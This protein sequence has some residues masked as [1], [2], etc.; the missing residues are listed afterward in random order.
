M[1]V[2]STWCLCW[3]VRSGF[4]GQV[5]RLNPVRWVLVRLGA[6]ALLVILGRRPLT[7]VPMGFWREQ[8]RVGVMGGVID[9]GRTGRARSLTRL[10]RL[11]SSV[12]I[13]W[14]N[15][16]GHNVGGRLSA[17]G[18]RPRQREL[19]DGRCGELRLRAL[20]SLDYARSD[21]VQA[22]S[23][24]M[25]MS[26][27]AQLLE[28]IRAS[29][30]PE[31]MDSRIIAIDGLGGAGKTTL[32]TLIS[33][34]LDEC[35]VIHTDDF[36]SWENNLDWWP[37]LRNQVLEPLRSNRTARYQR[38]DWI[39]RELGEWV[40]VAPAPFIILEGVSSSRDQ[41]RGDLSFTVWVQTPRLQRLCRGLAR[42][43]EQMRSYWEQWMRDEDRYF[44]R[45]RPDLRADMVVDGSRPWDSSPLG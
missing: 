35:P 33:S 29:V 9:Q 30:P 28:G 44:A 32:A 18:T 17:L 21:S 7:H 1:S 40:E 19:G 16:S 42:D 31:G 4:V 45:E 20:P 27:L 12:T 8:W 14:I 34:A 36:A 5:M 15:A 37:R 13:D 23:E 2:I 11:M 24:W 3:V 26:T 43:G 6:W 22:S 38:Y 41:F 10:N 25:S 39:A